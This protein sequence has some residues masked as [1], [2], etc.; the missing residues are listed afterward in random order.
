MWIDYI[1]AFDRGAIDYDEFMKPQKSDRWLKFPIAK[2]C[3]K[4]ASS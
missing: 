3:L 2:I 1:M 4:T